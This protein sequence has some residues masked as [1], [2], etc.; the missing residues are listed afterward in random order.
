MPVVHVHLKGCARC[1]ANGHMGM[2]FVPL[3]HPVTEQGKTIATH[4]APCPGNGEPILMMVNGTG[5][6]DGVGADSREAGAES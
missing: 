4:W 5:S 3:T 1:D 6:G 2:A